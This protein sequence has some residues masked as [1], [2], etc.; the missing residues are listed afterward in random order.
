MAADHAS[1]VPHAPHASDT[2]PALLRATLASVGEA[3][4]VADRQGLVVYMNPLA[5]ELTETPWDESV[6]L[7]LA[8]VF[9]VRDELTGEPVELD[10]RDLLDGRD[11][12]REGEREIIDRAVLVGREGRETPI[13]GSIA[14]LDDTGWLTLAFRDAGARRALERELLQREEELATA[15]RQRE[16]FLALLA[17]ELRNPLAPIRNALELMRQDEASWKS[18]REIVERQVKHLTR[19]VDDLLDV[20]RL[21]SGSI[22]LRRAQADLREIVE[23]AVEAA[24]PLVEERG[25]ALA[26]ELPP[27]AVRLAVDAAR[28]E[29]VLTNLL[30]NAAA[31][32]PPGGRIW[33]AVEVQGDRATIAVRDT[34]IGLP[35]DLRERLFTPFTLPDAALDRAEGGGLGV[36]LA[37]ARR[38]VELHGGTLSA[39]SEGPGQGSE[40]VVTLPGV[41]Q[42]GASTAPASAAASA[43]R[44][45]RALDVLVVDDNRDAAQTLAI[46]LEDVGPP[47]DRGARR[48]VGA[49]AGGARAAG[50]R[51]ARHRHAGHG[52]LRGGAAAAPGRRRRRPAPG[53]GDRVRAAGGPA[54]L[55][56][57]GVR[58]P[59]RQAGRALRPAR[60]A[61]RRRRAPRL[62]HPLSPRRRLRSAP[63][64]W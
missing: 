8:Q 35:L 54:A 60:A 21:T 25:H 27:Q 7:P 31:Y 18:S 17:H 16:E 19:L 37:L 32:T 10:L 61:R 22:H 40:F 29:Q 62:I 28:I 38:L 15:E 33:L 11:A 63:A 34:G 57:G 36:G 12:G 44:P 47:A 24:R 13:E 5:V 56:R 48:A 51:A 23:H 39:T 9:D 55:P 1:H 46:L 49:R 45:P 6:R 64:V 52:R 4:L 30:N 58:P 41:V 3:V 42:L 2:P 50:G 20:S 59:P 14:G 26:V 53:G 43:A